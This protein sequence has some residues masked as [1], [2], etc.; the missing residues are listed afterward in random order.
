M[1]VYSPLNVS[2]LIIQTLRYYVKHKF[3]ELIPW[4][5][6]VPSDNSQTGNHGADE[7]C[8]KLH[9]ASC[10]GLMTACDRSLHRFK[11]VAMV[12]SGRV[13]STSCTLKLARV[14]GVS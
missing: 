12:G 9:A 1:L 4:N 14:A 8:V 11:Y 3:V 10:Y 2:E 5:T 13:H 6:P 7:I